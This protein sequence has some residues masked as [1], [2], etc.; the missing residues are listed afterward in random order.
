MRA[1]EGRAPATACQRGG[2]RRAQ[3]VLR[4]ARAFHYEAPQTHGEDDEEL[5][6]GWDV[7]TEDDLADA[8][9]VRKVKQTWTEIG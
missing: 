1:R 7:T 8:G 5:D 4:H 9:L 2:R 6:Y 3:G